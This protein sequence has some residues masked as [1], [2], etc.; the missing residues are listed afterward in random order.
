MILLDLSL[1]FDLA[2]HNALLKF[3][4]APGGGLSP[5]NYHMGDSV[6]MNSSSVVFGQSMEDLVKG[7]GQKA[8]MDLK[9]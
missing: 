9:K 8:I 7:V 1:T 6:K 4:S 3:V 5:K 2:K